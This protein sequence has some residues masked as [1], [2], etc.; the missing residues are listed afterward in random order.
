MKRRVRHLNPSHAGAKLAFDAR[1]IS[2]QSDGTTLQTWVG[3]P[4]TGVDA[5]QTTSGSRPTY[6]ER[7]INGRAALQFDGVDDAYG[8]SGSSSFTNNKP[9]AA[10]LI[11]CVVDGSATDATQYAAYISSGTAGGSARLS[12]RVLVS[13]GTGVSVAARRLDADSVRTTSATGVTSSPCIAQAVCDWSNNL[14][15]GSVNG[16]APTTQT[17]SSGAGNSDST[18]ALATNIGGLSTGSSRLQGRIGALI[19]MAPT[20]SAPLFNRIRHHLG[21]SFKIATA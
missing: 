20:L 7:S 13:G 2:G 8:V 1:F 17:F 14:I 4:G 10:L 6:L 12:P 15:S 18:A 16:G 3:R 21:F 9:S 19:L 11:V 5:S